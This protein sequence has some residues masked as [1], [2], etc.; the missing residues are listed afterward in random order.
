MIKLYGGSSPNAIKVVIMLEELRLPYVIHKMNT[1][2]GEQY[3]EDYLRLNPLG[4]YPVII[5]Q[6]AGGND[7]PIFESAAILMYLAERYGPDLL[8]QDGPV[9]WETLKWLIAQVAYMGP[10]LGQ[11]N[12][13]L[14]HPSEAGSYA[15]LRYEEQARRVFKTWDG[16]LADRYYLA[17]ADYTV[18]DI[19]TYPWAEYL[20]RQGFS[21]TDFP[22]IR[23]WR[24]RLRERE[25]IKRTEEVWIG[26]ADG[27]KKHRN[28]TA[29]EL[30]I[31]FGRV[32]GPHPGTDMTLLDRNRSR[33][34]LGIAENEAT[35]PTHLLGQTL[36]SSLE[37]AR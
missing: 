22:N 34:E 35:M 14:M 2:K 30:D 8:P 26:L 29:E 4:K 6:N 9:R 21:W 15:A 25:A 24:E 12:H 5:D 7:A 23:L 20:V 36:A 19:A 11:H 17:G 27:R 10:M 18:A 28:P 32:P 1:L 33:A 31:F 37:Y 13:F 3:S 16:R